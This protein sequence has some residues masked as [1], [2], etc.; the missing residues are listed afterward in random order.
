MK[1][2][3]RIL[4]CSDPLLVPAGGKNGNSKVT[5]TGAVADAE[6][7]AAPAPPGL[8]P[9][10]LVSLSTM[11]FPGQEAFLNKTLQA[12]ADL[13]LDV[14]VATGPAIDPASLTAA[15]NAIVHR[16]VPHRV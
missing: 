4:V 9:R 8:R 15:R 2:A 6:H 11:A 1:R 14:V 5:W 16:Y 3:D 10:V 13:P 12:V 7:P